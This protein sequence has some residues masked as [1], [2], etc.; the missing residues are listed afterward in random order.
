[1]VLFKV[2]NQKNSSYDPLK[3]EK[4]CLLYKGGYEI[5][6][7]ANKFLIKELSESQKTYEQRLKCSSYLPFLSQFVD[8]FSASLFSDELTVS[9]A[10]DANDPNT[11]GDSSDEDFY[12]IFSSNCDGMNNSLHNFMKDTF[13]ESLYSKCA[14]VGIDFDKSDKIPVNLIEE[15]VLGLGRAY[16]YCIDPLSVIDWK[17]DPSNNKF[18]WIKTTYDQVLQSDPLKPPTHKV[19]FKIWTM[20]DD[21][22]Y[23]EVYESKELPLDKFP[24]DTDDFKRKDFGST[25]FTEIPIFE[26]Q[27]PKGLHIGNKLGPVCEEFFNRRSLLVSHMN[28]TCIAVPFFQL[29]SEISAPGEALP[30]EV[31]QNPNRAHN[32]RFDLENKG[33]VVGGSGDKF[34]IIESEGKSHALF[35]KHI[36]DL[37]EKM[38]QLINQMAQSASSN[39]K[40]LSRSALSKKEDRHSTEILLSAYAR[41]VKDFVKEIYQCISSARHESIIWTINGLSTFVEEDRDTIIAEVTAIAGKNPVLDLIPSETFRKKYLSRLATALIGT[42]SPEEEQQIQSE[43]ENGVEN[44]EHAQLSSGQRVASTGDTLQ[45]EAKSTDPKDQQF[46]Q[47][48]A[49]GPKGQP[50]LPEGAHL[51]TGE[52]I[53]SQVVFDQLVE[54]YNEKDIQFVKHIPWI[55]PV[56]TPLSSIDFSNKDNWQAS[57]EPDQVQ[58]FADKM[59]QDDFSK[60]VI[61]V[62]NPSNDN[63]MKII[64]GHHRALAAQQNGQPLVAYIGQVGSNKG[65]WDKLHSKQNGSTQQSLQKEVSNQVNKSETAKNGKTK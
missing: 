46:I 13:T 19:C 20:R 58:K 18:I 30:S 27:I 40:A 23:W 22:A 5:M 38:H 47:S 64:D 34:S 43:I 45:D 32:T 57:Q 61:L 8:H 4:S 7:Q 9:Q 33:F 62:N 24:Q 12:K 6:A 11:L 28:K 37:V 59:S 21:K 52:H 56:E 44:Q 25:S 31:Q 54:D 48:M 50:L 49:M 65:P 39:N 3:I 10:S 53:D 15:E 60:P 63:K 55:G 17:K 41:S 42:S 2:L 35:D 1:M 16:L 14:Y 36:N 29:G 26:L 51:Q